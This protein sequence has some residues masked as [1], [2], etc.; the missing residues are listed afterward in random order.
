MDTKNIIFAI[1]LSTLVL[2]GWATFFEPPPING[3]LETKKNQNEIKKN[4]ITSSP[5]IEKV[6]P[7]SKILRNE[8]IANVKRIS[9]ENQNIKGSISLEGAIIDDIT[10]KNY[11]I[12]LNSEEKVIFLNPKN[13]EEGYY[14]GTGWTSTDKENLDLLSE[15][16][17]LYRAHN[18]RIHLH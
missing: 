2:V 5:S 8:A 10:F 3:D 15:N 16:L 13:S 12:N 7:S 18:L 1:L 17:Y 6:T 11:N 4:N 9:L 14:I